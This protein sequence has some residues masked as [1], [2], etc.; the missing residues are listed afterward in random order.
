MVKNP[1]TGLYIE[2]PCGGC[3]ACRLNYARMWSIR[4]MNECS[5]HKDNIF[6]TLTYDE[7]N[8][9]ENH[10]I[11]KR[12][13]QLF[14]KK[15]RKS[16]GFKV[17]YFA[18]GEYGDKYSRPHYHMILFGLAKDS[19]VFYDMR[20][21]PRQHGYLGRC[22]CWPYGFVF[23]GDVTT[24]S[25][26][27]VAKYTVKKIK[28]KHAKEHYEHLGVEP[29]FALMSRRP[30]IGA[31]YLDDNFLTLSKNGYVRLKGIKYALPRYYSDKIDNPDLADKRFK[32]MLK[33]KSELS[34]KA[35]E[36]G[37]SY[38]TYR[39]EVFDQQEKNLRARLDLKKGALNGNS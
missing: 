22:K 17:R 16:L 19:D 36:Q 15:L 4:I 25:A 7:D 11:S 5:K 9:P 18:S 3:M 21:N 1:V 38:K 37:K 2:V 13:I 29:E 28:G 27:Y 26:N 35:R 39:N 23:V 8:L 14:M 6:L 33:A 10:S 31:D 12:E 30:G 20:Y 34:G 32:S 24:D